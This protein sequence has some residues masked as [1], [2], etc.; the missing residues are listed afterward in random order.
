MRE[1]GKGRGESKMREG[2]TDRPREGRVGGEDRQTDRQT[3][4][5]RGGQSHSQT[6]LGRGRE[7]GRGGR[8]TFPPPIHTSRSFENIRTQR[9][10]GLT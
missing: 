4:L 1:G 6:D 2:R 3:D 10:G 7:G 8:L 9:E 5:G